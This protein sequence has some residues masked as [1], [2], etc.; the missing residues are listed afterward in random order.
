MKSTG[1]LSVFQKLCSLLISCFF[2]FNV[3]IAQPENKQLS[4]TASLTQPINFGSFCKIGNTGG[5][6]TV[7]YN[8]S[9]TCTGGIVLLSNAPMATQAIY[10]I[11]LS[12]AAKITLTYNPQSMLTKSNSGILNLDVG[13]TDKGISGSSFMIN[14]QDHFTDQLLL[15]GTLHIPGTAPP[16]I[17]SGSFDITFN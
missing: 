4:I 9:R 7:A 3:S 12:H 1:A 13:P 8:G 16:G 6:V 11:T 14:G 10:E 15:G 2:C 5:T 17:Y